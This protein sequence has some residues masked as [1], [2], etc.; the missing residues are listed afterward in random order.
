MKF[1][2]TLSLT[3]LFKHLSDENK[4]SNHQGKDVLIFSQILLTSFIQNVWRAVRR[5]CIFMSGLKWLKLEKSQ[6]SV[7]RLPKNRKKYHTKVLFNRVL[8]NAHNPQTAS[9]T[10]AC[11]HWCKVQSSLAY[12]LF[13]V[14]PFLTIYLCRVLGISVGSLVLLEK[15]VLSIT[16]HLTSVVLFFLSNFSPDEFDFICSLEDKAKG[17]A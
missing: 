13:S 17:E 6:T 1:L 11:L 15:A 7:C 16:L 12:P 8:F 9:I 5:I 3:Y 4:Q 14:F 2:F 10:Q